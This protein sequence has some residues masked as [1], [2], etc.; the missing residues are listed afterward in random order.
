MTRNQARELAMRTV[1]GMSANGRPP[2][3]LLDEIFDP[4]YYATLTE[5]DPF[6]NAVPGDRDML[7]ITRVVTGVW[8]HSAELDGYIDRYS[9]GWGF[10]RITRSAVAVLKTA[11]F[12]ILYMEDVPDAAAI[13]SAV[14]IAKRY[15]EPETVRFINGVLGGFR[16]GEKPDAAE[17]TE[18]K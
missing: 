11:M 17:K 18:E 7:Y 14:E 10:A 3:E 4:E 1:F 6:Y 13:N 5:E 2:R 16:R 8:E 12:E 9:K 15:E